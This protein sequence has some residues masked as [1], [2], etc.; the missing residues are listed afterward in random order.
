MEG[1]LE[2]GFLAEVQVELAGDVELW[3]LETPH[4]VDILAS[5]GRQR[6]LCKSG[7]KM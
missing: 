7:V 2:E 5:R 4:V 1:A 6:R 3:V